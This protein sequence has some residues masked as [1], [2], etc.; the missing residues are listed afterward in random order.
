MDCCSISGGG[1]GK[2]WQSIE[3]LRDTR[4]SIGGG[5]VGGGGVLDL[6]GGVGG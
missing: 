2:D 3:Y 6:G 4:S 5:G 1:L